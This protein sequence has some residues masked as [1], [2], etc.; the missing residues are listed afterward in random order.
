VLE[1]CPAPLAKEITDS[2]EIP[3]IGIGAGPYCDAQILVFHDL[4]GMYENF[5]P[6]FVKQYAQ[7]GDLIRVSLKEYVHDV[8]Q[9]RFPGPEHSYD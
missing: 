7:I 6:K 1:A 5:T 3:T 8:E 2:L 4:L 9:G